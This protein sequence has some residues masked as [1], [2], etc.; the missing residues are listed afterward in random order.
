MEISVPDIK[1]RI[2]ADLNPDF[3]EVLDESG[4]HRGHKGVV[5]IICNVTHIGVRIKSDQLRFQSKVNQHRKIYEIL[6]PEIQIGLHSV[7]IEILE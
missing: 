1:K 7:R 5:D 6:Q 2:Q 4:E 3:L